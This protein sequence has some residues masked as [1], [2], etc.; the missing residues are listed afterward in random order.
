MNTIV[1]SFHFCLILLLL[2]A[3]DVGNAAG[4]Q[5]P[6]TPAD[7]TQFGHATNWRGSLLLTSDDALAVAWNIEIGAGRSQVVGL[8]DGIYL[9]SGVAEKLDGK[10]RLTNRVVAIDATSGNT[11]WSTQQ[12]SFMRDG[13]ENFGETPVSPQ[14]TPLIVG[15]N[16]ITVSFT[17][18]LICHRRADGE[19]VWEKQLVEDLGAEPVQF[20]FSASPVLDVSEPERIYVLA[21]GKAAGFFCLNAMDGAVVWKSE[22]TSCS[23]ATPVLANFGGTKQ[24]IV[25]S[26]DEV[27]GVSSADGKRLWQYSWPKNGL[28]NVPSP[29]V[30]DDSHLLISG[31]G[32]DGTSCLAVKMD[33]NNWVVDECWSSPKIKF[34]YTNWTKVS[35]RIVVGCT[36]KIMVA[37]DVED[38][39][40]LGRWRGFADGNVTVIGDELFVLDGKGTLNVIELGQATETKPFSFTAREKLKIIEA[41]CWTPFSAIGNRIFVRGNDRLVCL[42]A[43]PRQDANSLKNLLTEPK[44]LELQPEKN[45]SGTKKDPVELIFGTFQAEGQPAALA[46]YTQLRADKALD[47]A[48]RIAIAEAATQQGLLEVAR[49]VVAEAQADFPNSPEIESYAK[50]IFGK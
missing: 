29:L 41:R 16:L 27:F 19:N 40:T 5:Q 8:G 15:P 48:A 43:N 14:A 42:I 34:F 20:G 21:A 31:Q 47:E 18:H 24:W 44:L 22:C 11:K 28:T 38:G 13:Q 30:V 32:C 12:E 33:Q 1:S 9:T 39:S 4:K 3:A 46:I 26:E 17:G 49:M 35:D 7:V 45:T 25:V 2:A 37:L 10:T 6:A 36:D 50:S 23:Y